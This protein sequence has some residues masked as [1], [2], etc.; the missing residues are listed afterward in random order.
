MISVRGLSPNA[1]YWRLLCL[2][3][4]NALSQ[5]PSRLGNYIN[6]GHV[7][8]EL[9]EGDRLC[10]LAGRG[11]NPAFALVETAWLLAG[12]NDLAPLQ[13]VLAGYGEYSDDGS[14][15]NGAYGF[16]LRAHF[17]VDQIEEA[18]RQLKQ[19]PSTRRTVLSL[20][21]VDDLGNQS[22][23]I[24]CNTQVMLRIEEGRLAITIINRSNDLWLGV[25][26]NW[27]AFR[28][29]QYLIA[30]QLKVPLG[31]QRHVSTC[32]HLYVRDIEQARHVVNINSISSI[33][34]VEDGAKP[35][36]MPSFISDIPALSVANFD[37][38]NSHNLAT[39]FQRYLNYKHG[40]L[41]NTSVNSNSSARNT[42]DVALDNWI[43]TR[44]SLKEA[45]MPNETTLTNLD[46]PTH[47]A[48]QRWVFSDTNNPEYLRTGINTAASNARP[49]L[50]GLLS[51][52]L[53]SG[54]SVELDDPES[55]HVGQHIVLELILGCLDPFLARS[56][57]GDSL[58]SRL[59]EIASDLGLPKQPFKAREMSESN[60]KVIFGHI[61]N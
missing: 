60:L 34:E 28:A 44:N 37:E 51:E 43:A 40:A 4:K 30:A 18:I 35:M 29:L 14:T 36:D 31:L 50:R 23:D 24:P 13:S 32:M 6:L 2:A 53:P 48:L 1:A 55:V 38:I 17:G 54:V 20:F 33:R 52:G 25:P 61:L 12:R 57:I 7:S 10:L 5:E 21:S 56:E 58:R 45:A 15:L 3:T 39:F 9:D 26:Y 47:L 8:V 41:M 27:F 11:I 22:N 16:R 19:F 42:L 46:T 59:L 49:F